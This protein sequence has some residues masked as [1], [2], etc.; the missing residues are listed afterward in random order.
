MPRINKLILLTTISYVL[1]SGGQNIAYAQSR[2][3]EAPREPT[4]GEGTGTSPQTS[5]AKRRILLNIAKAVI[6]VLCTET[7]DCPSTSNPSS[8][9]ALEKIENMRLLVLQEKFTQFQHQKR[10]ISH[11][12]HLPAGKVMSINRR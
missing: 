10:G 8:T 6:D 4:T 3:I 7:G 12:A 2:N 11:L 1:F 5:S 9:D